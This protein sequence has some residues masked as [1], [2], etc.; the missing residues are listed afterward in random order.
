MAIAEEAVHEAILSLDLEDLST[1]ALFICVATLSIQ[2]SYGLQAAGTKVSMNLPEEL[3]A[4]L[5][6]PRIR[7]QCF[8]L[9]F[10]LG[11]PETICSS[12][13]HTDRDEICVATGLA[14]SELAAV[15]EQEIRHLVPEYK[16]E[17]H[18]PIG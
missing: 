9:R 6:L 4:V 11:L 17:A 1:D 12:L 14:V 15:G 3:R 7:R 8:V 16:V 13:L 10:L 5:N 18:H 2:R